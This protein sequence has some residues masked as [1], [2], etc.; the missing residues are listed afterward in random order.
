MAWYLFL[1]ESGDLGFD[2]ENTSC[3]RFLTLSVLAAHGASAAMAIRD[4]VKKTLKRK[5]NG[6]KK[7][8][9]HP[10]IELKGTRTDLEVKKFFYKLISEQEFGVYAV[11][12]N[13]KRV[14]E[15]LR[16]TP[17]NKDRL[18]NYV[19]RKVVEQIPFERA[20]SSV[21][22]IVDK[23]KGKRGIADFDQ[24]I[25]KQLHG[26]LDPRI[27]L[28]IRHQCSHADHGLSAA[29]LFCWGIF[30]SRERED[31]VWRDIYAEKILLDEQYL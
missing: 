24:Y 16:C 4:A 6:G 28:T 18:Y 13:K 20:S 15:E 25:V 17:S 27:K 9:K 22:L 3:S 8:R 14:N 31:C 29:D 19:A 30:R 5:V 1:D 11:T 10:A 23:S 12:L 2:F 7:S 21:E 26:R